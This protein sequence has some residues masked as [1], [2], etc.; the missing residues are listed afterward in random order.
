MQRFGYF[1]DLQGITLDDTHKSWIHAMPI[2]EYS[3][4]VYGKLKFTADR[5]KR[6]AT[7]VVNKIR[8]IDL[9][10]DYDHKAHHG[11]AAGWIKDAQTRDNGLWIL[12]EWT[13]T[14]AQKIKDKE[15]RYFSP[16]FLD[17]WDDPQG[18]K[19]QDVLCGG[20]LTNRP[21]LK[22]DLLPVN[23]SELSFTE[24]REFKLDPK[25][26]RQQLGLPEDATDQQVTDK[27]DSLKQSAGTTGNPTHPG[28]GQPLPA[29]TN[30]NPRD[31]GKEG[32]PS[33]DSSV[34][35]GGNPFLSEELKKLSETNPTIKALMEHQATQAKALAEMQS[36]LKL[37]EVTRKLGGFNT[38]QQVIAPAA[39]ELLRDVYMLADDQ[40]VTKLDALMKLLTE[41]KVVVQLGERGS[42]NPDGSRNDGD[43]PIKTVEA[44]I[45]KKLTESGGKL[46]YGDAMMAVMDENKELGEAYLGAMR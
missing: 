23:L 44:A 37:S 19:H 7:S 12:V 36:A 32:A 38:P 28:T 27:I 30:L 11:A 9:D 2:G 1:V 17:E 16:E 18:T 42:T 5:V 21:F 31:G 13:K 40:S 24:N 4:P 14:A 43:D 45:Q 6:F 39:A 34:E 10:I 26:L 20:G 25:A 3:H 8:K 15:Y 22:G 29:N 35:G 41:N 46:S 33:V